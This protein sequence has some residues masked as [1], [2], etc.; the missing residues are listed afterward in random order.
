MKK[1]LWSGTLKEL[2]AF[3]RADPPTK[4]NLGMNA[5]M[6]LYKAVTAMGIKVGKA[7]DGRTIK[8]YPYFQDNVFGK[9]DGIDEEMRLVEIAASGGDERRNLFPMIGAAGTAKS[10]IAQMLRESLEG[11]TGFCVKDCPMHENPLKFLPRVEREKLCADLGIRPPDGKICPWCAKRY[12]EL[13]NWEDLPV[14]EFVFS[15]DKG[16]GIAI[17]GT[18]QN[19]LDADISGLIGGQATSRLSSKLESDPDSWDPRKGA[20]FKANGGILEIIEMFKVEAKCHNIFSTVCGEG[21]VDIEG[22]GRVSGLDVFIVGHSNPDEYKSFESRKGAEWLHRRVS[23][24]HVGHVLNCQAEERIQRKLVD[25]STFEKIHKSPY[26]YEFLAHLGIL[27]RLTKHEKVKPFQKMCL[28]ANIPFDGQEDLGISVEDLYK[29]GQEDKNHVREGTTGLDSTLLNKIMNGALTRAK[30]DNCL[31]VLDL[32]DEVPRFLKSGHDATVKDRPAEMNEEIIEK[33]VPEL[34]DFYR[35][36]CYKDAVKCFLNEHQQKLENMF[37]LYILYC[38]NFVD[39][40]KLATDV[41]KREEYEMRRIESRMDVSESGKREWRTMITR[42]VAMS[43]SKNLKDFPKAHKAI[44]TIM[45]KELEPLMMLT[46]KSD[47]L[48]DQAEQEK[49]RGVLRQQL[50]EMGY[51][52]KCAQRAIEVASDTMHKE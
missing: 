43:Q 19:P 38:N 11:T 45:V 40:A 34:R 47:K 27:S 18:A 50:I 31:F 10:T 5:A 49:N 20:L 35:Q 25:L 4:E 41:A 13:E 37:H 30:D 51:C 29:E 36:K 12:G 17:I 3:A 39:N 52:A 2:I 28:Y 9:E 1:T 14:T 32:I 42:Q 6:R 26:T 24:N 23:V 48:S 22:I 8:I 16:Q 33:M 46:L 7:L 44:E 21:T 15:E